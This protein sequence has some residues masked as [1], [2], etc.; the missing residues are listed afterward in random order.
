MKDESNRFGRRLKEL[1]EQAGLTQPQLAE[2]ANLSKA[3]IADLE[4][5]RREPSWSTVQS[6]CAAL[7]VSCEAFNQEPGEREV[8]G[9]GRPRKAPAVPQDATQGEVGQ[10]PIPREKPG[11]RKRG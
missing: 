4:Q 7:A 6:L 5:G 8:T 10:P 2:R 9:R 3:G 11:K 1:R